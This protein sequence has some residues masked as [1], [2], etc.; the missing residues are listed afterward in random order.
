MA[1]DD[2]NQSQEKASSPQEEAFDYRRQGATYFD[3]SQAMGVTVKEAIRLVSEHLKSRGEDHPRITKT[4]DLERVEL[5]LNSIF[6]VASTGDIETQ[7][8]VLH[9]MEIRDRLER[10]VAAKD[11][12][13]DLASL[14]R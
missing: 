10:K 12:V 3:I 13:P 5:M 2:T 1:E 14:M 7:K 6:Q 11:G 8:Q 4:L 9:L